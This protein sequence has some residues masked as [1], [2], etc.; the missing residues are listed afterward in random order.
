MEMTPLTAEHLNRLYPLVGEI[1]VQWGLTDSAIHYLAF[2]M[3]KKQGTTPRAEKWAKMFEPRLQ[4]LEAMFV[5]PLFAPMAAHAAELFK[6]IRHVQDLRHYLI[7]GTAVRYVPSTDGVVFEKIDK[8]SN[9][10]TA[11]NPEQSHTVSRLMVR[12]TTIKEASDICFRLNRT[13][14]RLREAVKDLDPVV[15]PPAGHTA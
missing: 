2:A 7:H 15:V 13:L 3:F 12:F 9:A 11:A 8:A 4:I 6:D 10:E 1:I 14:L 5:R